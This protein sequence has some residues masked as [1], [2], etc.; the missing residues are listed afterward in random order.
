L[1]N[2]RLY[3]LDAKQQP[4]PIG[5]PGEL[6]IAGD[7]LARHYLNRPELTAASFVPDRF[8]GKPGQRMYRSGDLACYWPDGAIEYLGRIDGQVKLRGFRIELGEI[9]SALQQQEGVMDAVVLACG[10]DAARR[11]VAYVLHQGGAEAGA[12]GDALRQALAR[13]LPHYM[14]PAAFVFVE[15]YPLTSNGKVDYRALRALEVLEAPSTHAQPATEMEV[16]LCKIWAE[17]L[18]L[19]QVS[20]DDNFFMLGGDS[21][22]SMQLTAQAKRAGVKISPRQIMEQPTLR[23]LAAVAACC[24]NGRPGNACRV[25]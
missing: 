9:A 2:T 11:L 1:A 25:G 5:V 20:I 17:V 24:A 6:Y 21:L 15:R 13:Q 12:A 8:S 3:V 4:V 7:G 18:K 19:Q 14:V 22:L 10:E 16:K 23:A